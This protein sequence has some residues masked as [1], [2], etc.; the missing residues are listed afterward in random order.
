[1]MSAQ[2]LV[3]CLC[4]EGEQHLALGEPPLATAFYLAAFSCHAP[5]AVRS[6]RTALARA[7]GA[8]VLAT[9][10]AWCRGDSQIPAIHWDGMAVVS[11]TGSLASAFLGALCPDHPAAV[12][13]LLAA[14]LARGRHEEVVHRCNALLDSHSQQVLELRLTRALAWVLSGARAGDGVAAYLQ[15]FASSA[16]RTVAFI[17]THQQP[18]L[19]ALLSALQDY[20]SG[21]LGAGHSAS[22]QET[23]GQRL[24]AALDPRGAWSDTLSPEALLHSG[25]YEDCLAACSRTLEA[26]PTGSGPQGELRAALLVT[27]A[28]SAFFVDG[29]AQDV[30]RDL[31][32]AFR[33]SPSAAR[34]QLQAVFSARDQERVRAQA[35]EAADVGFAR[36]QEAVRNHPELR[37]DADRELLA[38]VIRALRVLLRLAPAGARPALG[39]RLAECL[40]LAGDA[41]SA[42]A[43]CERLLRPPRPEDP[44]GDRAGDRAPLLRPE[45]ALLAAKALVPWNQRGLLLAV[46]R[47]EARGM[48]QRSPRLGPSR[49]QGRRRR[50]AVETQGPAAQEGDARGVHQLATLLMELDAEDEASRLLAA[51]ALYRL[52]CLEEAHKVLLVALSRRPQ[53]APVLA[54]LALL[55]LRRGFCYDANQL[56]K[57]LVQSGETACLQPTLDVF[58]LEDRQ[59][60]Q[61][62]CHARAL[63]ILRARPVGADGR[64]HTRE[65]IAYLSLAIFA[66]GSEASESL[67]ARARCYGFL[68]QKKTAMFDFNAVLRAEPGNVQAL[69]GRALVHLA[70]DQLQEALDDFTS[71][72]K[73]G[74]ETVVPELRS[75][76]PEA[77]SLITQ[78]LYSRCRALLSQ[79]GD[80]GAPL[81]DK[82][83][84]G[85]LAAA[86]ALIRIDAPQPHWHLLLADVLMARGSYEEAGTHLQNTLN[87][88]PASEAARARLGLLRLKKGDVPGAARDLQGLAEAD[89][90]DLSCLLRLLETSERQS[91]AQAAAQE[92]GTLLDTGQP[93]RAL[94][95][96]SLSVLA[97]GGHACHLRLR[98]TCL[99]EL[100]EFDR[101]LRDLD[102]VL[103]EAAGDNDLPRRAEDFCCQG[104]LLLSLGDEAGAAGSFAQALKLAPTSAQNSLCE[105]PGRGPTARMF[106]LLGQRCLEE[107][108][109][110]EAWTAAESGLLVD[111]DHRGLKRLKARI[112]REA[113]S[114]CWLQ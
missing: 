110:A 36:F 38:P 41:A 105:R 81:K 27:R 1:V 76:K 43:L 8:A 40:L 16:N 92:A 74:P 72:L 21:H 2:E 13:H 5:S 70:L 93:G 10:E 106:L 87:S 98:A 51:D 49:A 114:G 68:G 37:E 6:V 112:R 54:R 24:L 61:G 65:A 82:D 34:G 96:C 77:R 33:E 64:A 108:R 35:Q 56:V 91:L 30:L 26:H 44:A 90:S 46:L 80:P 25:R 85:L 29:R 47:E 109:H 23:G 55:Q 73:L 28:A 97:G 45:D 53:A 3:A 11:L 17:R 99:A 39:I 57:K 71:A 103:Q 86:E 32:E 19:P 67:L 62:H 12:L 104:R 7:Q 31:Q 88:A 78:G 66:A 100:Q 20:L 48:L 58:C 14:L 4:R 102:R 113:S 79:L 60:L 59:L 50:E 22:Q 84:Q 69:C 63:A 94:G 15:A 52:G 101:A 75:L 111:P 95:Y 107:Q 9:L 89:A 42:R 18:Y 83:S